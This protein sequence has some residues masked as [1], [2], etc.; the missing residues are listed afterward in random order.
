MIKSKISWTKHL[1]NTRFQTMTEDTFEQST[2]QSNVNI[3]VNKPLH[4]P[5][6]NEQINEPIILTNPS[7][8]L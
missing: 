5:Q 4:T 6:C 7:L 8:L 1:P 2:K 3:K